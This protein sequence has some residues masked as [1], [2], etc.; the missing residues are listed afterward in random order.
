MFSS[1]SVRFVCT[2]VATLIVLL[3]SSSALGQNNLLR[4][5]GFEEEKVSR[6]NWF[7]TQH[8][9]PRAYRFS[10]DREVVFAGKQ[11]LRVE[12]IAQQFFGAVRQVH[13]TPQPG[14]YR[15][16]AALRTGG[17]TDKGWG[18]FARTYYPDGRSD[19]VESKY[20]KADTDWQNVSIE[21]DV[22]PGATALEI[23]AALKG[24]GTAW[25]DDASVVILSRQK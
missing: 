20:L 8:A 12:R 16:S 3:S 2:S 23:A 21:F 4:D 10:L 5:G 18:L 17:V 11:S 24:G 19:I 25:I 22:S 1:S 9:G 15:F 14:K 7:Y 13:K 6:D